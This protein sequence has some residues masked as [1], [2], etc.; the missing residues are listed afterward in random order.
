MGLVV[1]LSTIPPRFAHIGATLASLIAQTAPIDEIRLYIPRK[2]RRFPDYDGSL[3]DVP[4]GVRIIRP[5]DDLGPASKVLFAV[6]DLRGTDTTIIYCDDDRIYEPDRFA[7]MIAESLQRPGHCIAP[8]SLEFADM[9]L[10]TPSLRQPRVR[11]SRKDLEYRFRRVKQQLRSLVTGRA[12]AKPFRHRFIAGGYAAFAE[13]CGAVLIRPDYLGDDTFNIPPV[14]WTVDDIWLSGQMERMGVP[15]WTPAN[16]VVPQHDGA[17]DVE[18][19]YLAVIEGLGRHD[20]NRACVRYM[21]DTY[22]I[23]R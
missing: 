2:Y 12:L 7:R 23:W 6:D 16:F 13:G 21:Q 8:L 17:N 5:S 10:P 9:G 19:L 3:P 15:I 20:A 22:G 1:S 11:R 4:E 18:P 14:V